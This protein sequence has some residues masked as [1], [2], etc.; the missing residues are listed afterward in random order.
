[1]AT[2][3][4]V[5]RAKALRVFADGRVEVLVPQVYG[6]T[7]PVIGLSS[8]RQIG[9]AFVPGMTGWVSFEGGDAALPV[10]LGNSAVGPDPVGTT[11]PWIDDHLRNPIVS[12]SGGNET[13][14]N[15]TVISQYRVMAGECRWYGHYQIGTTTS[16]PT[17][18]LNLVVPVPVEAVT[19]QTAL[20]SMPGSTVRIYDSSAG[21]FYYG[22]VEY[23]TTNIANLFGIQTGTSHAVQWTLNTVP[24]VLAPGDILS[25]DLNYRV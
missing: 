15:G 18:A 19:F 7:M 8:G 9:D 22:T 11:P 10:W 25:W 20:A 16:W 1:M 4:G 21:L 23:Q 5:Y 6:P 13:R 24:I 3:P 12:T 2:Y 14:G 17:G